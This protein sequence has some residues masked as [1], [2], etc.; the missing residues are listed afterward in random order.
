MRGHNASLI[1]IIKQLR[2]SP[3]TV[4]KITVGGGEFQMSSKGKMA[5]YEAIAVSIAKFIQRHQLKKGD[6]LESMV[7]LGN[8]FGVSR[9]TVRHG[10]KLLDAHGVVSMHHGRSCQVKSLE[11][12]K[13]Y[14]NKV[15]EE[16]EIRQI[17]QKI[18]DMIGQQESDLDELKQ[19]IEQ[20]S[21]RTS[22]LNKS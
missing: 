18:T 17:Y 13:E 16:V 10:L 11:N 21:R 9:E 3:L 8:Q 22:F 7:A 20:L 5:T 2:F 15:R 1:F 12:A 4:F 19:L 6:S 14:I